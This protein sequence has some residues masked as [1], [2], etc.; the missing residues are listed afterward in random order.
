[1][2]EADPT[3]REHRETDRSVDIRDVN[4]L[5]NANAKKAVNVAAKIANATQ[6]NNL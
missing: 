6:K 5:Q 1:M 2:R 4:A 3:F